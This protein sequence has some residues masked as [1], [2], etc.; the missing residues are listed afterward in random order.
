MD[1]MLLCKLEQLVEA[2]ELKRL[3]SN[4][5][6]ETATCTT[7]LVR[8]GEQHDQFRTVAQ[9]HHRAQ[10][11]KIIANSWTNILETVTWCCL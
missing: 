3:E 7:L 6:V 2:W 5:N 9:A 8:V 4:G 1:G 10:M 11:E